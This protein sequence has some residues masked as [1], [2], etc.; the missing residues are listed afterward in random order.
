MN[1]NN[2]YIKIIIFLSSFALLGFLIIQVYWASNTFTEKK[3]NFN[4][5]VEICVQEIGRKLREKI[6]NESNYFQPNIGNKILSIKNKS[7]N[8]R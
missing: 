7:Q 2:K 3:N 5:V 6:L 1:N 8:K 4:N